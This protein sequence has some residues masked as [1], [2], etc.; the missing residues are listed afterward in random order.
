MMA[1]L[2][3]VRDGVWTGGVVGS[4]FSARHNSHVLVKTIKE[5]A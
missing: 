3:M 5:V 4:I 2:I 1:G